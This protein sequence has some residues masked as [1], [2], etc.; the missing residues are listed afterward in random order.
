MQR[1]ISCYTLT[2]NFRRVVYPNTVFLCI[3]NTGFNFRTI[4]R[5]TTFSTAQKF[6]LRGRA[7]L[8]WLLAIV[9][10]F[11][12]GATEP[13]CY[14]FFLLWNLKL[15]IWHAEFGQIFCSKLLFELHTGSENK[16]RAINFKFSS[17]PIPQTSV[18]PNRSH[19]VQWVTVERILGCI[20]GCM[21]C[22][23]PNLTTM[24]KIRG[25]SAEGCELSKWKLLHPFL[26]L[27]C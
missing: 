2:R 21:F 20:L 6:P 8:I 25:V 27:L 24:V 13:F 15:P 17:L 18:N 7:G 10:S 9:R 16:R 5:K 14:H 1:S 19:T 22:N 11:I 23:T 26:S 4:G 3:T 12:I